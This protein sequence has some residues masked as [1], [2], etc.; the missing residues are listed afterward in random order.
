MTA[1]REITLIGIPME[2]GTGRRGAG[3]GPDGYRAAMLAETLTE[4]GHPVEDVGNL[5]PPEPVPVE[6]DGR[7]N[8]PGL[9]AAWMRAITRHVS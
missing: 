7:A 4:L 6:V 8:D 3:M 5:S 1:A 9:C 2:A